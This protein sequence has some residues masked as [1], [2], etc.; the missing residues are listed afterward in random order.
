L[1]NN[2]ENHYIIKFVKLLLDYTAKGKITGI[3]PPDLMLFS[4]LLRGKIKDYEIIKLLNDSLIKYND[5]FRS[6]GIKYYSLE[7]YQKE[8]SGGESRPVFQAI[9]IKIMGDNNV[10]EIR[11]PWLP[12]NKFEPLIKFFKED[13][14]LQ[15]EYRQNSDPLWFTVIRDETIFEELLNNPLIKE[16][17]YNIDEKKMEKAINKA[18]TAIGQQKKLFI[19]STMES[20]NESDEFKGMFERLYPFQKVA[21]EYSKHRNGILIADEMG[22]GKTIQALAI[23]EYHQLYPAVIVVPAMIVR[24]WLREIESWIP[25]RT[26]SKIDNSSVFPNSD[27]YVVSYNMISKVGDRLMIRKPKCLIAD[28]SHYLKTSNSQRT[29]AILKYFENVSYRILTTGTPI[30]N[31]TIELAPQLELLG[32]LDSHFGGKRRFIRR[33]APPQFNGFGTI[34]TSANEEELQTELRKSCMI[35]RMKK[36]VLKELPDKIKQ[37]VYLPL[38]DYKKYKEV[39]DDS[40]NWYEEKLKKQNLSEIE[41]EE[42]IEE[43]L[44]TRSEYAEKMVK[45]EYLRQATATYKMDAIF[46]WVDDTLEQVDKLVIFAHHRDIIENLFN[47]YRNCSVMLY[48]GMAN[49]VSD[50]INRFIAEKDIKIFIGSLQ[51]AGIGIDGL[52]RICDKIA[53]VELPWTPALLSQAEDRLH[54]IG[55]QNPVNIYYLLGENTI[56]EYVYSVIG[57]KEEIFE[58]S[59]NVDRVFQWLKNKSRRS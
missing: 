29:I 41:V 23:I 56:D 2:F 36:D 55:Q 51:S 25:H 30:L 10:L 57:H 39:E 54:R 53:F 28:E 12:R 21:V 9:E 22:L 16:I 1:A 50:T 45:I 47:K 31:R 49:E 27:I 24:N 43:K 59:I 15:F 58:K 11:L 38:S 44:T 6:L 7:E 5:Y 35:R 8:K 17:G 26:A 3:S 32:V 20:I 13:L 42:L 37:V 52:Q 19:L 14:D 18:K 4:H 40:I 48:G 33:Y 46:E 34:Y